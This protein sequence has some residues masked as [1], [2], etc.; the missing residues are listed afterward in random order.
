MC[1]KEIW[2]QTKLKPGTSMFLQYAGGTKKYSHISQYFVE[3][4]LILFDC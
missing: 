4:K 1:S 2:F 3:N